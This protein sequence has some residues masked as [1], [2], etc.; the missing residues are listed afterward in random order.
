MSQPL[1]ASVELC[2]S[3]SRV[4]RRPVELRAHA[5][6]ANG[7]TVDLVIVDL[8]YNGCGVLSDEPLIAGERL[9]LAVAR[10]GVAP[11]T[12]CWYADGKAGLSFVQESDEQKPA[13]QPRRSERVS[14]DGQVTMRRSGKLPFRVHIYDLT[15]NGCRA[16]F[17][18]R[19][20]FGEQLWI[21]FDQLEALEAKVRWVAG[22]KTGLEFARPVHQAVFDLLVARHGV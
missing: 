8:S 13:Q 22:P 9:D 6:R 10:R 17:V 15:P 1:P 5:T 4:P 3:P 2:P 7:T 20:E 18:E 21:K 19:P 16:E 11:A 12:V 14:V